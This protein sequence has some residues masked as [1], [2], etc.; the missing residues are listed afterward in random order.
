MLIG[1]DVGVIGG[2]VAGL[3]LARAL[4]L[5]G[6][7]VTVYEQ[8]PAITEVGA[9]LQLS[10][11]GVRVLHAL[12]LNPEHV[13]MRSKGVALLDGY[14][15]RAVLKLDFERYMPDETFLLIHRADLIGLLE[16]GAR[17]AG[18]HIALGA[19]VAGVSEDAEGVTLTFDDGHSA[20]HH[21]AVGADGLHSR[22]RRMLN[23]EAAPFYTGQTAWRATVPAVGN[24]EPVALVHMAPKRHVVCYP[25]RDGALMNIVAVEER[26]DW[27]E[28]GWHV[29]G[30]PA[31]LMG[32]F[33]TF[34][35]GVRS[36]L[37][38]VTVVS[39]WGLFRHPVAQHWH[40]ERTAL[41]GDAAHPTL[42]FLAQGANLAL[43]D[44]WVLADALSSQPLPDALRYYQAMRRDRADRVIE[45]ANAN[46]RNYHLSGPLRFAG[47]T[48]LRF[49]GAVAPKLAVDKFAWLYA[50]DVTTGAG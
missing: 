50:H 40:G 11:N 9:G 32:R 38:R 20:R 41:V 35:Q 31:E 1:L 3:A 14:T 8:A 37:G 19:T 13:S 30:D 25:L 24:T 47:H 27:V 12:G 21:L 4:A 45:A 42:P 33:S 43:E 26:P 28:E 10:P 18:V 16:A 7:K 44:I 22:V 39:R 15:G 29:K 48:A 6:A 2:G 46:A 17:D 23:G 34:G 5:R 36:L 49:G